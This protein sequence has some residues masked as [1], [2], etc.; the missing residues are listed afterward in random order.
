MVFF[1]LIFV[2]GFCATLSFMIMMMVLG[3]SNI[4]EEEGDPAELCMGNIGY[5]FN[6]ECGLTNINEFTVFVN[7]YGY[8]AFP[9]RQDE[10][11]R[12]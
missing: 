7:K 3:K 12:I 11:D 2:L 9:E 1:Y 5:E 4:Q 8:D 10:T 6:Q